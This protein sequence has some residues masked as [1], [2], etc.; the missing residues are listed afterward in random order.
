MLNRR[1]FLERAGATAALA[2]GFTG[3][4]WSQ[5][6]RRLSRII[7]GFP[8]GGSNDTIA[9]LLAEKM[10]GRYAQ[11]IVVENRAGAGGRLGVDA[12]VKA[13]PDGATLLQTPGS[14]LTLYPHIFRSLPYDALRDLTPVSP[15]CTLDFV[16]AVGPATPARTVGEYVAWCKAD[17]KNATYASPAAGASPHFV[18]L[19]FAQ[20]AALGLTHVGYKGSAPAVQDLMGGQVPAYFG[21]L[22]DVTQHLKS[23]RL[24]VLATSGSR[25]SAAT[26][27]VPTFQEAGF[28]SVQ[29]QEWYGMLLPGRAP[30]AVVAALNGALQQALRDPDVL[31]RFKALNVDAAPSSPEAFAERIRSERERWAPVVKASGF[32]AEE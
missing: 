22:P 6:L 7:L 17:A 9:R 13:A 11:S 24:R 16:L 27:D 32:K 5:E 21:V 14:I 29:A 26:P 18:G 25:R 3:P 10:Q 4:A 15:I 23:G 8:A 1:N 31:E 19:M 28:G 2:S 12:V 20:A 30:A